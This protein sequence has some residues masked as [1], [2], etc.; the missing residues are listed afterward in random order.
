MMEFYSDNAMSREAHEKLLDVISTSLERDV[1][2]DQRS[3]QKAIT[4]LTSHLPEQGFGLQNT[5]RHLL[6]DIAPGLNASSLSANYYGFVTGGVTPAARIADNI[7]SAYDQNVQVH[8]PDQ[9]VA[10]DVE[11]RALQMLQE[12]LELDPAVWTGRTFT[13]GATASNVLGLA[14]GREAALQP[15]KD[16]DRESYPI[17][18]RV[19]Y[20]SDVSEVGIVAACKRAGIDTF[21][22]LSTMPH[23]SL[24]K[25]ASLVGIGR[26]HVTNIGRA[27][28]PLKFDLELLLDE[29]R[30]R[31]TAN[32]L[33]VSCG[34][35]NTGCFATEGHGELQQIR[36]IC[37]KYNIW[38]HVDGAFGIFGRA[39]EQGLGFDAIKSG[40]EG[41]ELADSITGD[42]HK[43]LNVVSWSQR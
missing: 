42:A 17:G 39:L 9:T 24:M 18:R 35:V 22:V 16:A 43:L 27:R 33:V 25:A 21:K 32:I 38:I 15:P 28:N 13:T 19:A 40:C 2:P 1:L 10:T 3:L 31:G 14:C 7:V 4:S 30:K 36:A 23:S 20:N 37:D 29:A 8:L 41:L 34:E 12:M 6:D 26:A 11:D 5:T